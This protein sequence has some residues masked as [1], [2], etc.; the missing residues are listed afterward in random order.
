MPSKSL[1][2]NKEMTECRTVLSSTLSQSP[3]SSSYA[4]RVVF[5]CKKSKE[6]TE[7]TREI[8]VIQ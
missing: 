5:G 6:K 7:V 3:P 8:K 4:M 2:Q 1:V